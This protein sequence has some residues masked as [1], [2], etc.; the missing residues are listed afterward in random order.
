MPTTPQRCTNLMNLAMK[1]LHLTLL[2]TLLLLGAGGAYAQTSTPTSANTS[3]AQRLEWPRTFSGQPDFA[4]TRDE[5]LAEARSRVTKE[6]EPMPVMPS[7]QVLLNDDSTLDPLRVNAPKPTSDTMTMEDTSGTI[8]TSTTTLAGGQTLMQRLMA[9]SVD[10]PTITATQNPD[11]T[12]F[13]GQLSAT[14][15]RTI[16]GWQP[17]AGRYN[18]ES[19]LSNL[20]LQAI[21]TSPLKYAVINQ[22]KYA[23]GETFRLTVPMMVPDDVI[24]TAMRAQMPASGTLP[25][26]LQANYQ[27]AFD[28][29]LQ[30]Y[31]AKRSQNPDLG[32]QT[33]ILPVRI[34]SIEP[35]RVQ[36]DVNGQSYALTIR[37]AY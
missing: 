16:A 11:L 26:A 19:V 12:E 18:F 32:R 6:G 3:N 22:Q 27:K 5:A 2:I 28:D 34:V 35:R 9:Q 13:S 14:I 20:V 15:S 24:T 21:V 4:F 25:P 31:L 1:N 7:L 37:Y 8:I 10:L 36:L 23:E 33:L 17:Q 29:S 30:G